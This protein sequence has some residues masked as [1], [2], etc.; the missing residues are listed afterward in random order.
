MSACGQEWDFVPCSSR[1]PHRGWRPLILVRPRPWGRG[2]GRDRGPPRLASRL[3]HRRGRV[4]LG[5]VRP[6]GLLRGLLA[7]LF[8]AVGREPVPIRAHLGQFAGTREDIDQASLGPLCLAVDL[9]GVHLDVVEHPLQPTGEV[10]DPRHQADVRLTHVA[11]LDEQVDPRDLDER[12]DVPGLAQPRVSGR[13]QVQ[14]ADV[15]QRL[16]VAL[17]RL[18]RQ[19]SPL[20]RGGRIGTRVVGRPVDPH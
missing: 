3:G 12:D 7:G 10:L 19:Q 9:G 11:G 2:W 5:S 14:A 1:P 18:H 8:G 6:G 4:G 16:R 13:L 15:A 17:V 20:Q